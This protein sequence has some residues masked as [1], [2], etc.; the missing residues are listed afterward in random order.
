MEKLHDLGNRIRAARAYAGGMS[1]DELATQLNMSLGWLKTV[2]SGRGVK[3]I[4]ALG[5][6]ERVSDISRIPKAW[7][8]ADWSQLDPGY[9]PPA[10]QLEHLDVTVAS[11]TERIDRLTAAGEALREESREALSKVLAAQRDDGSARIRPFVK[12]LEKIEREQVTV[13]TFAKA[14]D[15]IRQAIDELATRLPPP[16]KNSK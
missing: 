2:E 13:D 14:C 12:R 5:L 7:F 15:L 3:D 6:I 8:T 10:D 11:L 1:Q 4:E 16:P 9:E